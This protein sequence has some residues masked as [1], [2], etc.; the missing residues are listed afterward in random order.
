MDDPLILIWMFTGGMILGAVYFSAL[1][2]TVRYIQNGR[3]PAF[4]L[5]ASLI[6]RMT[7][8]LVAFYLIL[9]YGHWGHLLAVLAGFVTL[10]ILSVR[11]MRRQISA[12]GNIK[13]KQ[14]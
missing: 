4:W 5:I 10:R 2:F 6:L 7:V 12:S 13:E 14:L 9:H 11:S 1:W 8:L 3:Y